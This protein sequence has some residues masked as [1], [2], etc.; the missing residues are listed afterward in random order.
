MQEEM[1]AFGPLFCR[2]GLKAGHCSTPQSLLQI[3]A[4]GYSIAVMLIIHT[5]CYAD[6]YLDRLM[7]RSSATCCPFPACYSNRAVNS[8]HIYGFR[9]PAKTVLVTVCQ[10]WLL[11]QRG[12]LHVVIY[13]PPPWHVTSLSLSPSLP[14][15][16]FGSS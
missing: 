2:V 10:S 4:F 7:I 16:G 8:L 3:E 15:S 13:L 9:M 11:L 6:Y 12:K 5:R 14:D 1:R